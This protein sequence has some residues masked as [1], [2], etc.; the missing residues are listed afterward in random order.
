MYQKHIIDL[1]YAIQLPFVY[2]SLLNIYTS[3][4]SS[5]MK[6]GLVASVVIVAAYIILIAVS[7][8]QLRG[9]E[10]QESFTASPLV[11]SLVSDLKFWQTLGK[12]GKLVKWARFI[13]MVRNFLLAVC[14]ALLNE[15]GVAQTVIAT[16]LLAAGAAFFAFTQPYNRKEKN[17]FALSTEILYSLVSLGLIVSSK[18]VISSSK[19]AF[20]QETL[21]WILVLLVLVLV[22]T[23]IAFDLIL[24]CSE[25][26][27]S[28]DLSKISPIA[29]QHNSE[30]SHF[31]P[32]KVDHV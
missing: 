5:P 14:L 1:L 23:T 15:K 31:L 12:K 3:N 10:S 4:Q 29:A 28:N 24:L 18:D 26:L 19:I 9:Y 27:N 2:Y 32:Q 25:K 6:F 8:V 17:M 11:Q 7:F 30:Q 21:N 20:R 13:Q 16:V 22:F